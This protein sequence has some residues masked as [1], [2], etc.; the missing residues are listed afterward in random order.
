MH[1]DYSLPFHD[2]DSKLTFGKG[3]F[4]LESLGSAIFISVYKVNGGGIHY[5][6]AFVMYIKVVIINKHIFQSLLGSCY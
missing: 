4:F 1:F 2:Y 5:Q 6:L 3:F